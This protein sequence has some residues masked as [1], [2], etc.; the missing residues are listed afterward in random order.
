MA[1]PVGLHDAFQEMQ[2]MQERPCGATDETAVQNGDSRKSQ[3]SKHP[4]F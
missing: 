3:A 1:A 4:N 2:E